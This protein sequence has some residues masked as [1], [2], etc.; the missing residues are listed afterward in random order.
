MF[1]R[2]REAGRM[3]NGSTGK[4][5]IT[6]SPD[7]LITCKD[8][9]KTYLLYPTPAARLW[10]M[11]FR[12]KKQFYTPFEALKPLNFTLKKGETVGIVGRN[13]SGK[14]TLLQLLAGTLTATSGE[15]QVNGKV[16]ALLE[17]GA[18]F[19]PEFTG[20]ENVYLNG[21]ILGMSKAE[22]DA[23]YVGIAEFAGI[24]EFIERPVSTYSSGMVVRLAFAVATA[25]QPEILIVD[26]ALSVGD[27]AFQ[28]KCFARIEAMRAAGTT[29]LFVSH[30]A[31]MVIQLCDR[32]LWLDRGNL[33]L[34]DTPKAVMDAYHKALNQ[35]SGIRNREAEGGQESDPALSGAPCEKQNVSQRGQFMSLSESVQEY[36]SAGARI[37]NPR[38]TD[39]N[40]A[41]VTQFEQGKR[42]QFHYDVQMEQD[43][44]NLRCGML[45]KTRAGVEVAG[46]VQH[47]REQN[48]PSV[49]AGDRLSISFSFTCAL[50]PNAYFLNCGVMG[51]VGGNDG[52]L[53][54][55]VD[56]FVLKVINPTQRNAYGIQP[57]G[58]V[59]LA[60]QGN[61]RKA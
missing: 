22:I 54:R 8:L 53:H 40:G 45:I 47:L 28:R 10:Q 52:Y 17:L 26:E 38:L 51:E 59:D 36:P 46:A 13:G 24:G 18:G 11:I 9:A 20:R 39:E 32:A 12:G 61:T 33:M 15:L 27:E 48:I 55:L 7:H 19:N 16:A 37:V 43:A 23:A 6:R 3:V 35:E 30:S 58:L 44:E 21:S 4:S 1:Y 31:Q 5:P 60:V 41:S 29:I 25:S 34:D 50:H 2:G 56:A 57:S 49:K 42:Y 14:S